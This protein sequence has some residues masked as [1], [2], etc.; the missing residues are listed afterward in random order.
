ML[1][2]KSISF[3]A[4][5]NINDAIEAFE[6]IN[7]KLNIGQYNKPL[8]L[9]YTESVP[10]SLN[11]NK[12]MPKGL[13]LIKNFISEAEESALMSLL[14]NDDTSNMKHRK[15]KHYGY[16]FRYDINNVDK[17]KPIEKIPSECDFVFERLKSVEFLRDFIPDQLT[18]NDYQPGQGIP[19]HIDTHSAFEDPLLSLSLNSDVNMEF[20]FEGEHVSMSL[21]RR[22]LLVMSGESR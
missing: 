13:V 3:I 4:Y 15:V 11:I 19:P 16:E 8:Y 7:G 20:R 5:K 14:V 17:D 1:P 6:K 21:P 10:E 18:I 9:S 12:K 2:Q 22:S